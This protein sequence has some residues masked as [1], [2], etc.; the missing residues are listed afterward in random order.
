MTK[1]STTADVPLHDGRCMLHHSYP[2]G[3]MAQL[4]TA[5][6]HH[7]LPAAH[8]RHRPR[9][10]LASQVFEFPALFYAE[11]A[12]PS[13]RGH[14]VVQDDRRGLQESGPRLAYGGGPAPS[15]LSPSTYLPLP[16]LFVTLLWV[17]PTLAFF[18]GQGGAA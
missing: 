15:G 14:E 3:L 17:W 11:Y 6:P 1:L 16:A 18:S 12:A 2:L 13:R 10:I 5:Q 7:F 8:Y 9:P 4:P